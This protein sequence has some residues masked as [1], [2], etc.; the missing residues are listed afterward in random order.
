[1]GDEL[2]ALRS[3]KGLSL[4]Q[5]EERAK[6]TNGYLSLLENGKVR[7][8]SPEIL[9]K[10]A[11]AY[12]VPFE[13]LMEKAGYIAKKAPPKGSRLPAFVFSATKDFTDEEWKLLQ[14]FF[15]YLRSRKAKKTK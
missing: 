2:K 1:M 10:L 9:H 11:K 4:R 12:E 5:V 8:P 6:V 7:Q 15:S 13:L 3:Q 14:D